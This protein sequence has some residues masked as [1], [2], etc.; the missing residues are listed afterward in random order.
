LDGDFGLG[1]PIGVTGTSF[2][3]QIEIGIW[4]IE[5]VAPKLYG[6]FGATLP[7]PRIVALIHSTGIVENGE[8]L[9]NF[10]ADSGVLGQPQAI[11]KNPGPM[12]DA[13]RP[14]PGQGV[15]FK[16]DV[17]E[18]FEHQCHFF[19]SAFTCSSGRAMATFENHALVRNL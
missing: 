8:E 18:G 12:A 17:D 15:I 14:V 13:M 11:F 16:D 5:P 6:Q 7:M 1:F 9:H 10:D 4:Q 2:I 19:A 3:E